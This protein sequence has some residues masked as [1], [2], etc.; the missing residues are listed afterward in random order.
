MLKKLLLAV[1]AIVGVFA[2]Y[3]A[4]QPPEVRIARQATIAVLPR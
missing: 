2:I 4:L 1:V 3:V